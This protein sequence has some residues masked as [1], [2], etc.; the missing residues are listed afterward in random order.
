MAGKTT[1]GRR[2]LITGASAGIGAAV[3]LFLADRGYKVWGTTRDLAKVSSFPEELREKV[4]FLAMDVTDKDS[5][6]R[7]VAEFL[8]QAGGID[9]LINNAGYGVFGPIEEFPVEKVEALFGVNYFGALRV[10]QEVI[11]VMREQGSGLIIN[12]TSLAGTFV[13]PFQVHY[14]ATKYALE[15]LTEGL[16]Q[17]LRPFGIKVTAVAPGDIKTRFNDVTDREMI[18]DSPY[19]EWAERCWQTIE[20]NMAKAPPPRVIAKK[21]AWLAEKKNPGPTYPAGDFLSVQLPLVNRFIPRR[22]REKLTRCFYRVD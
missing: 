15:A 10:L 17:E 4:T 18:E 11:P 2:V 8:H 14:S 19:R 22:L 12:V 16:R 1:N 20:E 9:I 5:V 3:A 21:V 13:I 7:G 6:H